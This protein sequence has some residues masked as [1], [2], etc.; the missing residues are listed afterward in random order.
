M[1][2][3]EISFQMYRDQIIGAPSYHQVSNLGVV[4]FKNDYDPDLVRHIAGKALAIK[5]SAAEKRHLNLNYIRGAHLYIPE[6]LELVHWPGRLERAESLAGTRLEVYPL[7]IISTVVTFT[8][9]N[10]EDGSIVW[11]ADGIPVTELVPLTID[12]LV[13]GELELYRGNADEGLAR[14]NSGERIADD[15]I[16]QIKHQ[17]GYSV[18]GQLMRLMHRVRPVEQGSRVTLNLNLRS[19]ERPYIDDNT[20]CYLAADNPDLAWQE[21]YVRDLRDRLLPSYMAQAQAG[22]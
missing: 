21:E 3:V 9:A 13:G 1:P 18:L 2:D 5:R 4:Q 20:M 7:S 10:P 16:V 19:L 15:R 14:Y 6:I 11:H 17:E 12:D 8:S 22:L